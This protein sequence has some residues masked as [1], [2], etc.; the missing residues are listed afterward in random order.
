M[1]YDNDYQFQK[2][3]TLDLK[4]NLPYKASQANHQRDPGNHIAK[5]PTVEMPK[6]KTTIFVMPKKEKTSS[7]TA[8]PK[9]GLNS[10]KPSKRQDSSD[11]EF[12]SAALGL[13]REQ[14]L[15]RVKKLQRSES[16]AREEKKRL[17]IL[18]SKP[19]SDGFGND[20]EELLAAVLAMEAATDAANRGGQ[21]RDN[22]Q[23]AQGEDHPQDQVQAQE[24]VHGEVQHD[25]DQEETLLD[26]CQQ[27]SLG[28]APSS[29]Y[30][31]P[32]KLVGCDSSQGGQVQGEHQLAQ[33]QDHPRDQVQGEEVVRD[34]LGEQTPRTPPSRQATS[35]Q[36]TTPSPGG[37]ASARLVCTPL[38]LRKCRLL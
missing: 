2:I 14:R 3:P 20:D 12:L 36:G 10:A 28:G 26:S 13:E 23:P 34:S 37:Q 16:A 11:E 35:S 33:H 21:G 32:G 15:E 7:V 8:N 4:A 30:W 22:H 25:H 18:A 1:T 17:E 6:N 5:E 24:D 19:E 9:P 29:A 31:N 38:W 27:L